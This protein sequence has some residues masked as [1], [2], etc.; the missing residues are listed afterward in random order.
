M[1]SGLCTLIGIREKPGGREK[2]NRGRKR[3]RK[4]RRKGRE[5]KKKKRCIRPVRLRVCAN[6]SDARRRRRYFKGALHYSPNNKKNSCLV[7]FLGYWCKM[8]RA[9][10]RFFCNDV[11][12][13]TYYFSTKTPTLV[14]L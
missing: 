4:R 8:M 3:E 14:P 9:L 11:S 10:T 2:A 7:G 13:Q 12:P 5:K 6:I 1:Y